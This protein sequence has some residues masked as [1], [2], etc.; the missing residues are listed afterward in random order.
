MV[1]IGVCLS[2]AGVFDGAEIHEAVL[3]LRALAL[4]GAQAVC[5]APDKRQMHVIN[6][7]SGEVEEGET[8]NVLMESARIARGEV[9]AADTI[10]VEELDALLFPGGFGAA[11]NLCDFATAGA[12]C[13]VDPVIAN[14]IRAA[15]ATK[16]PMGFMCIAPT[17]CA[18]V[19]R[20]T[21]TR[22]ELT[23]GNDAET[24]AAIEAMGAK[25]VICPVNEIHIDEGNNV[26]STPAY[27]L[28]KNIAE[29]AEG[30]DRLV[31]KLLE[32]CPA[33]LTPAG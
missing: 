26:L 14:I 33:S 25:H 27:M 4:G 18:A 29:A 7:S 8:R 24:A 5:F 23:I 1:R 30:I 19:F 21:D 15:H 6:H 9:V 20:G 31:S 28:A 17:I 3:S 32:R 10:K 12:D 22:V 16:M 11:K 13:E 2:G